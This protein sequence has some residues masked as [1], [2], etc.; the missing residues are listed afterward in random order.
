LNTKT[1]GADLGSLLDELLAQ[2]E[3]RSNFD[4]LQAHLPAGSLA[5]RLVQAYGNPE[6]KQPAEAVKDIVLVRLNELKAGYDE[7]GN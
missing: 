5:S 3:P 7:P 2:K 4:R 6:G 1:H